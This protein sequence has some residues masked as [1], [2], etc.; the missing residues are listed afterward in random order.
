MSLYSYR[1]TGYVTKWDSDGNVEASY[2]TSHDACTCP[3]G[4]RS[5]CR[6]RAML[7]YLVPIADTHWF[8]DWDNHRT[9]VDLT[10]VPKSYYDGLGG[11]PT[12][13]AA[14]EETS[15]METGPV[16]ENEWADHLD[17]NL[18]PAISPTQ[19]LFNL[20]SYHGVTIREVDN[21]PPTAVQTVQQDPAALAKLFD[22][23]PGVQLF[24]LDD[25]AALHN[26]IADAVGEPEAKLP[27]QPWRRM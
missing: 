6:H 12:G 7:R 1:S 11:D 18:P 19:D 26:A 16:T 2:Q 8:L 22:L 24:T 10:G 23:P 5:S 21:L 13:N 27:T 4:V 3:A 17:A 14:K 15:G 20:P 25:P 9:I